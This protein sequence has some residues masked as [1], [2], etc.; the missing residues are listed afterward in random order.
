M[1]RFALS[2]F[3]SG[4]DTSYQ[5]TN[6]SN[7]NFS[8]GFSH[9]AGAL[10]A[11]EHFN[12]RNG[13]IVPELAEL[14]DCPIFFDEA[15]SKFFDTQAIGHYASQTFAQQQVVP[16]SI[17]GPFFD[18]PNSDLSTFAQAYSIPLVSHRAFNN[19]I[20]DASV[21][22]YT[23][24]VFPDLAASSDTL[25]EFL[26]YK[27]RSNYISIFYPSADSTDSGGQR[28]EALTLALDQHNMRWFAQP[29]IPQKNISELEQH[30]TDVLQNVRDRG[31]R[32][33]VVALESTIHSHT[34]HTKQIVSLARAANKLGMLEGGNY[35]WIWMGD[36][37]QVWTD[38]FDDA[39]L[40]IQLLHG[41]AW[42]AAGE[43]YFLQPEVEPFFQ[44]WRQLPGTGFS[45]RLNDVN[46]IPEGEP[47]YVRASDEIFAAV[48]PEQNNPEWGTG[49][50]FD[51][52]TS[53]GIGAC[54]ASR[55][56]NTT[57]S[58]QEHLQAIRNVE[59]QGASGHL[60]RFSPGSEERPG[61]RDPATVLWASMNFIAT[62]DY[63]LDL[64]IADFRDGLGSW[65]EVE[66]FIYADGR[67]VPPDLLR[68]EPEQNY[69]SSGLRIFGLSL[70]GFA[71]LLGIM[72][73]VWVYLHRKHVVVLAAQPNFLYII[74]FGSILTASTIFPLSVGENNGWSQQQL[75]GACM[76][77]PWL[78]STGH[79]TTWGAIYAKLWRVNRVLQPS[80]RR[81][82]FG[83]AFLPFAVLVGLTFVILILWT[84]LNPVVWERTVT[85]EDTGESIGRCEGDFDATLSI[86]MLFAT[87]LAGYY[88][89]KTRDVDETFSESYWI[90]ILLLFHVQV[91]I[92]R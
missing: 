51:A 20:F 73:I 19:R 35:F 21:A 7:T 56:T 89:W 43:G 30:M 8:M 37:P 81:V 11:M 23:S 66:P 57:I 80:H 75:D 62:S 69:L 74:G 28:R 87:S 64:R 5:I 33:I 91:A 27:G 50:L 12:A 55:D 45:A 13:S 77:I 18:T 26:L 84:T 41:S 40:I 29:Y 78:L 25:V 63:G 61:A 47:G 24:V 9:M 68:D 36:I 34:K 14:T 10:L 4:E 59:F 2:L 85:N 54:S 82:G 60:V 65:G 86:L 48:D 76:A 1:L 44:V 6:T 67:T 42:V 39:Q 83:R 17:A 49:L 46:P 31:Y 72:T 53:I 79:M 16:C 92:I 58:G 88:A 38:D 15:N 22:P 3:R 32:T 90:F 52:I 70:M 71:I